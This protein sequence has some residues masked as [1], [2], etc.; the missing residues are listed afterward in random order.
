MCLKS[1][2]VITIKPKITA[3]DLFQNVN[4][5]E[6]K[7]YILKMKKQASLNSVGRVEIMSVC[8]RTT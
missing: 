3:N 5:N 7:K 2:R 8:S 1:E 6:H 4:K